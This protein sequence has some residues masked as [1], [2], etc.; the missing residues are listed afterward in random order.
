VAVRRLDL[1]T[2]RAAWWSLRSARRARRRLDRDGLEAVVALPP[3]P[4]VPDEAGRGVHA[5]LR[6]T[7]DT[8]LVRSMVLQAWDAAHGRRRDLI[9]GTTAPSQGFEAHA[10]L[11]GDPP[12]AQQGFQ[13]LLRRPAR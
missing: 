11:E 3:V 2:L 4:S 12:C 10:W 5:V 8:C 1:S 6:R 9:V 7:G 13:E